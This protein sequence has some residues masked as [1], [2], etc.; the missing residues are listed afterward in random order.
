MN[1]FV[2]IV[3]Y[4]FMMSRKIKQKKREKDP[5]EELPKANCPLEHV[6]L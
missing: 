1:V 4:N 5:T 3:N 2:K 6:I